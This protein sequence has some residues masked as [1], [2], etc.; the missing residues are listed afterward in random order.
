MAPGRFP[1]KSL[2]VLLPS[3]VTMSGTEVVKTTSVKSLDLV[4]SNKTGEVKKFFEDAIATVPLHARVEFD[5][6]ER[7]ITET[8]RTERFVVLV[9]YTLQSHLD[10]ARACLEDAMA[11]PNGK[12]YAFALME[13][14]PTEHLYL[15]KTLKLD[16]ET[17]PRIITIRFHDKVLEWQSDQDRMRIGNCTGAMA[18]VAAGEVPILNAKPPWWEQVASNPMVMICIGGTL[19]FLF[20]FMFNP[21]DPGASNEKKTA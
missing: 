15:Q 19:F 5:F 3:T 20:V 11:S 8:M 18:A 4:G 21:D 2:S 12:S 16:F 9:L 7:L 14:Q 6:S 13:A 17:M 1:D 10:R